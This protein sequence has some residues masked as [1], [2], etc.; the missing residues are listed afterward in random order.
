MKAYVSWV[1]KG[2]LELTLNEGGIAATLVLSDSPTLVKREKIIKYI[3][4]NCAGQIENGD[5][6][7]EI[8]ESGDLPEKE[9]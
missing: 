2:N 8:A 5:L 6:I 1:G 4:E 9:K 3:R 7:I